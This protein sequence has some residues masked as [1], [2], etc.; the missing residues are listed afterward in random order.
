MYKSASLNW[1]PHMSYKYD[2]RVCVNDLPRMVIVS[3]RWPKGWYVRK[4]VVKKNAGDSVMWQW[5]EQSSIPARC[6]HGYIE[7]PK[8]WRGNLKFKVPQGDVPMLLASMDAV[9]Q[10]KRM[11]RQIKQSNDFR[12]IIKH[13]LRKVMYEKTKRDV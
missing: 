7:Y 6:R 3:F 11:W 2:T 12:S 5:I 13:T 9:L 8:S 1:D 4:N 10:E